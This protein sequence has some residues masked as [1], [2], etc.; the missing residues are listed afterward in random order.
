[1][2]RLP[3]PTTAPPVQL[4]VTDEGAGMPDDVAA[5]AFEPFFTTKGR[6]QGTGLGLATVHGMAAQAGGTARISTRPG[7]GTSVTIELPFVAAPVPVALTRAP[8]PS[9][10]ASTITIL[11]AEDDAGTRSTV[12]RIL[13]RAGYQVVVAEDGAEAWRLVEAGTAFNLLLSDVMMPGL[14]GPALAA[15]V[16]ER[17]PKMPVLFM[18]GYAEAD[19]GDLGAVAGSKDLITK[20]FS[21]NELTARLERLLSASA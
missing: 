12:A 21:S 8:A 6:G 5:R 7:R 9:A 3:V 4:R 13:K 2:A 10:S 20:P 17:H 15:R 16:R 1:V 11:I 19:V 14:N 18:T